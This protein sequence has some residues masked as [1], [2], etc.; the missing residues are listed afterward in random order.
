AANS[1]HRTLRRSRSTHRGDGTCGT[2]KALDSRRTRPWALSPEQASELS[3]RVH[4]RPASDK[5]DLGEP[6]NLQRHWRTFRNR[7]PRW[8]PLR[9]FGGLRREPTCE[10]LWTRRGADF[11]ARME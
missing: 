1:H 3:A 2:R 6:K 10:V 5:D 9:G 11:P 8:R 7:K 4:Q